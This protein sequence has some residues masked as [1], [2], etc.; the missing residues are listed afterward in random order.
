MVFKIAL[1]RHAK[2]PPLM[3]DILA[4]GRLPGTDEELLA[5]LGV[6]RRGIQEVHQFLQ[7]FG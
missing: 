7:Q 4:A 6:Y 3:K 1:D 2:Q 5:Y